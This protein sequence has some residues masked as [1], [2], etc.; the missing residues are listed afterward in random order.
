VRC[1]LSQTLPRIPLLSDEKQELIFGLIEL[2]V[3]IN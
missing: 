3:E 1:A 2:K